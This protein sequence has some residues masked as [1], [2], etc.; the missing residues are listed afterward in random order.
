MIALRPL[1]AAAA[2]AVSLTALSIMR[3]RYLIVVVRGQSMQPTLADG[4]RLLVRR[5][6]NARYEIGQIVVFETVGA[7]PEGDP[8]WRIK[9]VVAVAGDR[10]PNRT[11]NSLAATVPAGHL[12]VR[13]D[14]RRSETSE[15]L[16]YLPV[17][18][19]LGSAHPRH[20]LSRG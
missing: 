12:A 9:R 7:R 4:D 19:I 15:H 6:S 1:A 13:G 17:E 10:A 3:R 2:F 14:N 20:R 8:A 5:V 18:S 16:G 11:E